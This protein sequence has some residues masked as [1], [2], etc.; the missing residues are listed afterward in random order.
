MNGL[1][2]E[3]LI[4]RQ[5]RKS[6]FEAFA[7]FFSNPKS[8]HFVG[9]VKSEE[10]AYR[11]MTSY[12]GHFALHGFSYLAVVEKQ[13]DLLV[14]SVGLW[15]SDPWP[16]PELGYWLLPQFHGMG[17]GTEAGKAVKEYAE[18]TAKLST[19]VSYI[20]VSNEPSKKLALNLG[21]RYDGETA[22]LD[23]GTHQVYRYW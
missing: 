23:F 18:K 11:L 14:G 7:S 19:L 3:R 9:G 10:E 16:E 12:I 15:D 4:F 2:T 20:D 21:A 1:E 22:L 8:A 17:Y 6:D 13:S 5:W